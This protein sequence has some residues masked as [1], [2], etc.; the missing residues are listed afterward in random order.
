MQNQKYLLKESYFEKYFF[1]IIK[2]FYS[3][4]INFSRKTNR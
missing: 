3:L 4:I 1:F 2:T